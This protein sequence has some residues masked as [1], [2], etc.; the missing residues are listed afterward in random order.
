[1]G[2][3]T[4]EID[5]QKLCGVRPTALGSLSEA[6]RVFDPAALEPIVAEPGERVA[7]ADGAVLAGLV[8]VDGS[9]LPAL[10]KMAWAS[11]QDSTHWA[12]EMHVAFGGFE[13]VPR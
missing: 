7:R 8:A 12:A 11:W 1:M 6:S 9:L 4:P 2:R 3:K 10:P 5:V 13:G